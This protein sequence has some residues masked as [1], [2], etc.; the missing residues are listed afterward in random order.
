MSHVNKR[1]Q[2]HSR[3]PQR[4]SQAY[5]EE[6]GM[7]VDQDEEAIED[8]GEE[9]MEDEDD[10]P[11]S[12][13]T[14]RT[15]NVAEMAQKVVFELQVNPGDPETREAAKLLIR[16]MYIDNGGLPFNSKDP[17]PHD[18]EN[19]SDKELGFVVENMIIHLARTQKSEIIAQATNAVSNVAYFMTGEETLVTQINSDSVLRQALLDTF[20]GSR[21][22]PLLSLIISASSHVTNLIRSYVINGKRSSKPTTTTQSTPPQQATSS[23][24]VP[25][26]PYESGFK[27]PESEQNKR[28]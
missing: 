17:I 10:S 12:V 13:H 24:Y 16:K 18:L 22:S 7:E 3:A 21:I 5:P 1:V 6:D 27:H 9:D 28:T 15:K 26:K 8:N 14:G 11:L 4:S 23:A 20:L 25:P 2:G 19:L